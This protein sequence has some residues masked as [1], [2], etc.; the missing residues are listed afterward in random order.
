MRKSRKLN[1]WQRFGKVRK[2]NYKKHPG[3]TTERREIHGRGGFSE[4]EDVH[5]QV[6][7]FHSGELDLRMKAFD[8]EISKYWASLGSGKVGG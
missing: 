3:G 6:V 2:V 1:K 8:Y 4:L 7:K 5:F